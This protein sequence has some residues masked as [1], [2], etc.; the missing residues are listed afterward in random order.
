MPPPHLRFFPAG[1]QDVGPRFPPNPGSWHWA[2]PIWVLARHLAQ[3]SNSLSPQIFATALGL[4][5]AP[6]LGLRFAEALGLAPPVWTF[7]RTSLS[8]GSIFRAWLASCKSD[9]VCPMVELRLSGNFAEPSAGD[10]ELRSS[11]GGT[12]LTAE[13]QLNSGGWLWGCSAGAGW[14]EPSVPGTEPSL[15]GTEP[16]VPGKV[17]RLSP[18]G[19]KVSGM[20]PGALGSTRWPG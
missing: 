15:P 3:P 1:Y 14:A 6:A 8:L 20:S 16:S 13:P 12:L 9:R 5:F 17:L 10:S 19:N 7:L 4:P 11:I 2:H 18:G